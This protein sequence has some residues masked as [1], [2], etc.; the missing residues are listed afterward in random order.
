MQLSIRRDVAVGGA[1]AIVDLIAQCLREEEL[2]DAEEVLIDA[3][4]CCLERYDELLDRRRQMLLLL[5]S[6]N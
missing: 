5:P 2:E 3:I 1:R 4:L 6:K